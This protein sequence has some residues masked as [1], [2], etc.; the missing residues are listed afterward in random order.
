MPILPCKERERERERERE[1][2]VRIEEPNRKSQC[3]VNSFTQYTY[4]VIII[5]NAHPPTDG[6]ALQS[7]A[8]AK[9]KPPLQISPP[10][11]PPPLPL[12]FLS[13]PPHP[14]TTLPTPLF[15]PYRPP[16]TFHPTVNHPTAP[17]FPLYFCTSTQ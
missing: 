14:S 2:G 4:T 5:N 11:P 15:S 10:P 9:K 6:Q 3:C 16:K 1:S 7:K 8:K 13:P 17:S 12:S